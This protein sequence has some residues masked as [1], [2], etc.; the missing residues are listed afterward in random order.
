AD[1]N[2]GIFARDVEIARKI[3]E[4]KKQYGYPKTWE[5][6]YAKNT[7]KHLRE[8][9]EILSEGGVLSTGTLSLQSLDQDTLDTIRRSNISV[10]K[11]EDLAVEFGHH[12]LPLVMELMMGL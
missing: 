11:Y 10:E 8:I 7:V 9:I 5:S 1:A 12:D 4:L 6:S 3:V 2:F